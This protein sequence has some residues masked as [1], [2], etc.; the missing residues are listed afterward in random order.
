MRNA[1]PI[2]LAAALFI[3]CGQA[4]VKELPAAEKRQRIAAAR[5]DAKGV[6]SYTAAW[7]AF[8]L[9][10]QEGTDL[11]LNAPL[12]WQALSN[13]AGFAMP[14]D[15]A[16]PAAPS[17]SLYYAI[18]NAP[19]LYLAEATNAG[20]DVPFL[21]QRAGIAFFRAGNYAEANLWLNR[22]LLSGAT[23]DA[24]ALQELWYHIALLRAYHRRDFPGALQALDHVKPYADIYLTLDSLDLLVTRGLFE[25]GAKLTDRA[26]ATLAEAEKIDA[27]TLYRQWDLVPVFVELGSPELARRYAADSFRILTNSG[28]AMV[29]EAWWRIAEANRSLKSETVV[30]D[31][32]YPAIFPNYENNA[33]VFSGVAYPVYRAGSQD[34]VLPLQEKRWSKRDMIYSTFLE[35]Y[36]DNG[37]RESTVLAMGMLDTNNLTNAFGG[38]E[39][40]LSRWGV[41]NA[42]VLQ[43][44]PTNVY[45]PVTNADQLT[46]RAAW[47][48]LPDSNVLFLT[49]LP[50]RTLLDTAM[51]GSD[52]GREWTY[53]FWGLGESNQAALSV[54]RPSDRS[55]NTFFFPLRDSF[56]RCIV[57]DLNGDDS[58]E[59]LVLDR[60]ARIFDL[61][62]KKKTLQ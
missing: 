49:N 11:P 17:R 60:G 26:L 58:K 1:V 54:Y 51:I 14:Q 45:A 40:F 55:V 12:F 35:E 9:G 36:H 8:L 52:T 61:S 43:V 4:I 18:S 6:S 38:V 62:G 25:T 56:T 15:R 22:A 59:L 29:R 53:L 24:Y 48:V 32:R 30:Y 23:N 16:D 19:Y 44:S 10:G 42:T 27:P 37:D 39:R 47:T 2:I 28:E 57:Q 41:S 33:L 13:E 31:Y 3:S 46:N 21:Y 7:Q 34:V 5:G 50:F 20:A